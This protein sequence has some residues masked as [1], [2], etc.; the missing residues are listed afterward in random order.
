MAT[1]ASAQQARSAFVLSVDRQGS[2]SVAGTGVDESSVV[3]QARAALS[4]DVNT[5]LV[6]EG[7]E[8][9]PFES[10]KRAA[11]LL[12][13]AGATRISFRTREADQQ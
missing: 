5:A 1:A 11:A 4:R 6:V 12:Q 8:G 10:V 2:F 9:A 3:E 7:D 13:Q